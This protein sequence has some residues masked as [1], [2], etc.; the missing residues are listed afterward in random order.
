MNR[1]KKKRLIL[2]Q[3]VIVY[4]KQSD[5]SRIQKLYEHPQI[6]LP[7][8]DHNLLPNEWNSIKLRKHAP[9]SD[10]LGI[11]TGNHAKI[12]LHPEN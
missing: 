11:Q 3:Y 12:P 2:Y 4:K 9:Y 10:S 7:G 5:E 1:T 8:Y 6:K